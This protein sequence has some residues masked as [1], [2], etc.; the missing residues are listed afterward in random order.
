MIEFDNLVLKKFQNAYDERFKG[1][2]LKDFMDIFQELENFMQRHMGLMN[3]LSGVKTPQA[4]DI[5]CFV[6]LERIICLENSPWHYAFVLMEVKENLPKVYTYVKRFR[7]YA[8]F[9]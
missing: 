9:K 2:K 7:N 3:W 5:H 4:I 8:F 6:V 1:E